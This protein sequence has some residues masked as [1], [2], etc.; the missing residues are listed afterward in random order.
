MARKNQSPPKTFEE[1]VEELEAIL[2]T[3]ESGELGLEDTLSKFER[4]NFLIHHCRDVLNSAEKQI[5]LISKGPD[6]SVVIEPMATPE[7]DES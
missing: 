6:G 7:E 4:G 1:A 3:I 2:T 5:E